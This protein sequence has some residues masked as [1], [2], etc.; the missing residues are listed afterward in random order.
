MTD[1]RYSPA[2]AVLRS[3]RTG[4]RQFFFFFAVRRTA[5]SQGIDA[6]DP[7]IVASGKLTLVTLLE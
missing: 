2:G 1:C 4:G 3:Q 6:E 5:Q 7:S